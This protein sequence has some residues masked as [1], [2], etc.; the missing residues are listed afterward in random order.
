MKTKYVSSDNSQA[1]SFLVWAK[2]FSKEYEPNEFDAQKIRNFSFWRNARERAKS[3]EI[4]SDG[5][6]T[7]NNPAAH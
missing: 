7:Q 6:L 3:T 5:P 2:L 4:R 1:L